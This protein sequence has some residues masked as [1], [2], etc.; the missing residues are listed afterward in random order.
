[1]HISACVAVVMM[2]SVTRYAG[3]VSLQSPRS[4]NIHSVK[5]QSRHRLVSVSLD[6]MLCD[7]KDALKS[8]KS[9]RSDRTETHQ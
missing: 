2:V 6:L 8:D 1:M 9:G 5:S 7:T 3:D 4:P